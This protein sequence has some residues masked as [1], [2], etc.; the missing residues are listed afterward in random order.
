MSLAINGDT[1]KVHCTGRLENGQEI[2]NTKMDQPMQFTIGNGN[3]LPGLENGIVGM[4]I[5]DTKTIKIPPEEAYG[6]RIEALVVEVKKKDL[7]D[8]ILPHIGHEI[9]YKQSDGK[10]VN[11]TITEI[12][13]DT[14]IIDA[15]HPLAGHKLFF[16][17]ELLEIKGSGS[18]S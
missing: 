7:S 16:D 8:D 4:Q 10:Q 17:I 9:E 13:P 5:G 1:V 18:I 2:C 3:I 11:M 12:D 15:N 14:V 6:R